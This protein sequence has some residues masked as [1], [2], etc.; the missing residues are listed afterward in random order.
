MSDRQWRENLATLK[1][2][3]G[4]L[5]QNLV[6]EVT[7]AIRAA[8]D[9]LEP[10][11]ERYC[12]I[13]C[14]AC[15]DICCQATR[16]FFNH[17]DLLVILAMGFD[18]PPGQTRLRASEPCRYLR[19]A[20][21]TLKRTLRPYVCVWYLCE[22]QMKLYGEEPASIQ[23]WFVATLESLRMGRLRLASHYE[24]HFPPQFR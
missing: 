5:D 22:A 11:M 6:H 7:E 18:P 21:C 4:C 12:H 19:Q 13:T 23:R 20:G 8:Y 14:P 17:T 1:T 16:V 24:S 15:S 10:L 2:Q 9:W 3:M